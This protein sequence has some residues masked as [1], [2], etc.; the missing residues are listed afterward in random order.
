M[1][2][3]VTSFG[4]ALHRLIHKSFVTTAHRAGD[5]RGLWFSGGRSLAWP[6]INSSFTRLGRLYKWLVGIIYFA[7][8]HK[9]LMTTPPPPAQPR[10]MSRTLILCL[11]FPKVTTTLRGQLAGKT[12]TVLP[13]R[14]SLY[15]TDMV[16]YFYQTPTFPPHYLFVWFDSLSPINNLSVIK[17][18]VFLGRTSTKLRLMFLLKDTTQ[19]RRWGSN[20]RPLGL[21]SSTLPLSH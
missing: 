14:L 11:Q 18:W 20:P 10:G 13:R 21:E 19:W 6:C 3:G 9:S 12:M 8:M 15:C 7:F 5:R 2:T 16:A 4:R 17:G 1:L